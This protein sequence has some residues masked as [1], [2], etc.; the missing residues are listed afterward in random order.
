MLKQTKGFISG[1]IACALISV[2]IMNV[3][4][5][6][7]YK[8]ITAV[9]N[10]IKIIINGSD[11]IPKDVNG[12]IV[13]PFV[14]NGTTYLPIRAI[15]EAFGMKV[16]W[17]SATQTINLTGSPS[18]SAKHS[19]EKTKVFED[20]F[21]NKPL[22]EKWT[23]T[24]S[25]TFDGE[26]GLFASDTAKLTLS[27]ISLDNTNNFTI[28]FEALTPTSCDTLFRLALGTNEK[29]KTT[30][31][32]IKDNYNSYNMSLYY[33]T[34]N[35]SYGQTYDIVY[36]ENIIASYDTKKDTW[37]KIKFD[38]IN[39]QA[40]IYIDNNLVVSQKCSYTNQQ[41]SFYCPRAG[42]GDNHKCYI[43]NFKLIIND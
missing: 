31:H 14:Y 43:R 41:F 33:G 3:F 19:Q 40:N 30:D 38:V 25:W 29:G 1:F 7:I 36:A 9:Y 2:L 4:A 34:Y 26:N 6:P 20:S 22:D 39:K 10:D 17:N 27:G 5:A 16:D 24:G 23:K 11:F 12:N 35:N 21:I 18:L 8:T 13:E 37:Y 28:E 15:S 42:Y 32:F